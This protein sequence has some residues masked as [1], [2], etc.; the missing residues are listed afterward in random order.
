M[1]DRQYGKENRSPISIWRTS[2][3]P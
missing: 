3:R 1:I 2:L